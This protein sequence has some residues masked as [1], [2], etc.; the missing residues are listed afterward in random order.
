[1]RPRPETS[2]AGRKSQ[3]SPQSPSAVLT[4]RRIQGALSPSE[5]G[6]TGS[7]RA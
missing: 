1:M 7:T 5:T 6:W 2:P 4:M 3:T